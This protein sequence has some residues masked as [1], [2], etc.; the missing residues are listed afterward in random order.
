MTDRSDFDKPPEWWERN[1]Q[2]IQNSRLYSNEKI[3]SSYVEM[4]GIS[5][6]KMFERLRP[7]LSDPKQFIG[8]EENVLVA[9]ENRS[10]LIASALGDRFDAPY[11]D[12]FHCALAAADPVNTAPRPSAAI[13]NVDDTKQNSCATWWQARGP[14][15]V[16]IVREALKHHPEA[17]LILNGSLDRGEQT[18]TERLVEVTKHVCECF[19]AWRLNQV[20]FLG[21]DYCAVK[22]VAADCGRKKPEEKPEWAGAFQVYR[23]GG[24]SLRMATLRLKFRRDGFVIDHQQK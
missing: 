1:V 15:L 23:S 24:R 2:F 6:L 17:L 16:A 18:L 21:R 19:T 4:F 10:R 3:T 14:M 9:Y 12:F 20:A 5:G 22:D 7:H 11:G 8:V 13:F